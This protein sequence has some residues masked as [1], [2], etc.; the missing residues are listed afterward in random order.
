MAKDE[1]PADFLVYFEL[2]F[3]T[4]EYMRQ[5][6]PIKGEWL[7]EL[8]PHFYNEADIEEAKKKKLP[9]ARPNK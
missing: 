7:T 6:A 9:K 3:T 4:K 5:V 2:A 8:A 1:I